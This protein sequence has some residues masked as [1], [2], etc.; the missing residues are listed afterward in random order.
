MKNVLFLLG[1]LSMVGCAVGSNDPAGDDNLGTEQG[2]TVGQPASVVSSASGGT[3]ANEDTAGAFA[4]TSMFDPTPAIVPGRPGHGPQS[5]DP[6]PVHV[7]PLP[8]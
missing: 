2:G 7:G 6:G 5:P 8:R 4:H 3:S 1:A